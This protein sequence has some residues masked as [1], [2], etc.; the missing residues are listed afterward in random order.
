MLISSLLMI[1][2]LVGSRADDRKEAKAGVSDRGSV[3]LSTMKVD[4]N[5]VWSRAPKDK[6]FGKDGGWETISMGIHTNGLASRYFLQVERAQVQL[7]TKDGLSLEVR[8]EKPHANFY[9]EVPAVKAALG[10]SVRL[11][12]AAGLGWDIVPIFSIKADVLA[13]RWSEFLKLSATLDLAVMEYSIHQQAELN[14]SGAMRKIGTMQKTEG[15]LTLVLPRGETHRDQRAYVLLN[16]KKGEAL[17]GHVAFWTGTA[18]DREVREAQE[19]RN[20]DSPTGKLLTDEWLADSEIVVFQLRKVEGLTR[21]FIKEQLQLSFDIPGQRGKESDYD[22]AKLTEIVL[23]ANATTEQMRAYVRAILEVSHAQKYLGYEDPQVAMLMKLGP[24]NLEVLVDEAPKPRTWKDIHIWQAMRKMASPEHAGLIVRRLSD[25]PDLAELLGETNATEQ[26]RPV[27]LRGLQDQRNDLPAEWIG[28]I[29]SYR[30]PATYPAI[31][32]YF[33]KNPTEPGL[34]ENISKLPGIDLKPIVEAAWVKA[35]EG[36]IRQQSFMIH[37]A[38]EWG[39]T[40]ALITAAEW[41]RNPKSDYP[42]R[43]GRAVLKRFTPAQGTDE[44]L[45]VWYDAHRDDLVF[46]AERKMFLAKP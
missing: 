6:E 27:L 21:S 2:A 23:P 11:Y 22:A 20:E 12:A 44:E 17:L 25:T 26:A 30:D 9:P 16:K 46:S 10:E 13:M 7:W 19:F 24:K 45:L 36:N 29:L 3:D 40:D 33:L 32:E 18:L 39:I 1:C 41:L 8:P 38:C 14:H 35:K 31:T 15:G 34:Y 43:V 5:G 42:R 37:G 4:L 28:A